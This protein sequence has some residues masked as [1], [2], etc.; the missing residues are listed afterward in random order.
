[1]LPQLPHLK[2]YSNS[3]YNGEYAKFFR[4]L[5]APPR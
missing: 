5:G 3:L 4:C 2:D 1:V